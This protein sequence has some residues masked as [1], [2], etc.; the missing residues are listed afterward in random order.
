MQKKSL[1]I[2]IILSSVIVLSG[3]GLGIY[4][5]VYYNTN[6]SQN[7]IHPA[8]D[9]ELVISGNLIGVSFN[10]TMNDIL[11]MPSYSEDYIIQGSDTYTANF[12]G[13]RLTYLLEE[14]INYDP[15]ATSI[16][17]IA[18]DTFFVTIAISD[19]ISN[20]R[21]ILAYEKNGEFLE[22]PEEDGI[23]YLRLIVPQNSPDD[24]NGPE[25]LKNIVELEII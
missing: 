22:G 5:G 2:I 8:G 24:F 3:T 18:F 10:I 6:N 13:V 25:C 17:F 23:G 4:F 7:H 12:K 11:E 19:I 16:K 9:W 21:I 14:I 15:E 20:E 1:L